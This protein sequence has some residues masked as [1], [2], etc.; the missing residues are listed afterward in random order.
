MAIKNKRLLTRILISTV[1]VSVS[2]SV[3]F[4]GGLKVKNI[5]EDVVLPSGQ[6]N[7]EMKDLEELV[8]IL[9]NNWYSEIYYGPD[10]DSNLLINQFVG[11]LSTNEEIML[12]KFTYLTK[13]TSSSSS[14]GVQAGKL[15]VTSRNFYSYPVIVDIDANGAA[16]GILKVGDIVVETGKYVNGK[17]QIYTNF[18]LKK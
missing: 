14:S 2:L 11:A 10:Y 13:K 15:G 4:I 18:W 9:K 5:T 6:T 16:N 8:S 1:L 7:Q 12:D 3:G 17:L